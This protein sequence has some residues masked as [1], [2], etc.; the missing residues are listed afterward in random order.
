MKQR[1]I[2]KKNKERLIIKQRKQKKIYLIKF[3]TILTPDKLVKNSKI[4]CSN[5]Q[6]S[7]NI[8]IYYFTLLGCKVDYFNPFNICF[9]EKLAS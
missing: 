2:N 1:K 4:R 6:M 5:R 8:N 9:E 3:K 7:K